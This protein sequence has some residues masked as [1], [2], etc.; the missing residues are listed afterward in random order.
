MFG[1]KGQI[2]LQNPLHKFYL[3]GSSQYD[4]WHSIHQDVVYKPR[5]RKVQQVLTVH[6]L[7]FLIERKNNPA[8]I[9]DRLAQIQ[10][11]IDR[12]DAITSISA[13]T[14]QVMLEH[15]QL[16]DK[17]VKVIYNGCNINEFP[18]YDK[19][20]YRPGAPFLFTIGTVL[21]KKNFHV[22]PCLLQGN[23]YEL[24]IAGVGSKQYEA[25]IMKEAER[26]GVAG[27]V[28]LAGPVT[29]A[30]KY[31]YYKH[32]LAFV[33]PSLA[34]GFGFPLVEAMY[35][36]KPCFS[37]ALTSLP[38]IGGELVCYFDSFDSAAMQSVFEKGMNHFAATQPA[39]AIR[40]R[41]LQFSWATAAKA[42][43]DCYRR[44]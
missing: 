10:R 35:Y 36:G 13:F 2:V 42:Y 27:R 24:V 1:E 18:G 21:P 29:E 11:N 9:K 23:H 17:P 5:S 15:L 12:A 14:K 16:K 6:D 28:V 19:P 44:L 40:E 30:D 38:E 39:A 8:K 25:A 33:F 31:W 22:L 37:S 4:V 43:L 32:C 41:A 26:L 3:P 20:V 34:E 7:N